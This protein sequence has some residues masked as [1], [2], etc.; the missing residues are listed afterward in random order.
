M[1]Y[2]KSIKDLNKELVVKNIE[3]ALTDL[4][5]S[6]SFVDGMATVGRIYLNDG[7][8]A[9]IQIKV[10]RDPGDFLHEDSDYTE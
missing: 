9:E 2:L 10:T 7:A 3:S 6:D 1:N 5:K 4:N 8:T